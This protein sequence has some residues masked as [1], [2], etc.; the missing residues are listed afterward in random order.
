MIMNH[1]A[2]LRQ[3]EVINSLEVYDPFYYPNSP[4]EVLPSDEPFKLVYDSY[5][6]RQILTMS[7]AGWNL[8]QSETTIGVTERLLSQEGVSMTSHRTSLAL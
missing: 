1:Y 7:A 5:L 6:F 4:G 3:T 2:S 8:I